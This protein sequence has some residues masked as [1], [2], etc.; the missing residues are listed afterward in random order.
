VTHLSIALIL[1]DVRTMPY[2]IS[3]QSFLSHLL[4]FLCASLSNFFGSSKYFQ[5]VGLM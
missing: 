4:A 1:A 3:P 2:C 5:L